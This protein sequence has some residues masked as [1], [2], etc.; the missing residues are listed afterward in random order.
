MKGGVNMKSE[1]IDKILAYGL[2][3]MVLSVFLFAFI[4][5][6]YKSYFEPKISWSNVT[7]EQLKQME[8]KEFGTND[9]VLIELIVEV[10]NSKRQQEM[11]EE[12]IQIPSDKVAIKE[13][14]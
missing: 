8:M 9:P 1:K 5:G 3:T 11:Y 7:K 4:F 14:E 10:R 6:V 2:V 12:D 13:D